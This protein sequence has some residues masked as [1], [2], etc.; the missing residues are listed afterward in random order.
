MPYPPSYR[1][2][3]GTFPY[4]KMEV[5]MSDN[6]SK[7]IVH[8]YEIK[9]AILF[10]NDRVFA[11]AENP[12]A[13][14]PFVTW[15]FTEENGKRDYYWGHYTKNADTAEKD[16]EARVAG[17]RKDYGMSEKA[18]YK[19]YSTQRPIDI[20]TF[21]KTEN[22]PVQIVNFDT[23]EGVELGKYQAWG[24]LVYG[25]PLTEKQID[26]YDLRA[27]PDNPDIKK[28][29][30]ELSQVVGEWE[31]MRK[32]PDNL[33]FTS[34]YTD[35]GIFI[36]KDYITPE[37]M[38]ERY[39]YIMESRTRAAQN[40]ADKKPIA[41]QLKDAGKQVDRGDAPPDKKKSHNH[42]DR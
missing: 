1:G 38:D 5:N 4:M 24:Y 26:D 18:V 25:A 29:M 11:L 36:K 9:R 2:N 12:N 37:Q 35:F 34:W 30:Q 6:P 33:R 8:G 13:P 32:A 15:Q 10:E 16:Y 14:Q 42:E 27:A 3:F 20:G 39:N 7:E 40:K 31:E 22:G 21:P 19:Y 28:R 23:R 41:D 17:Y